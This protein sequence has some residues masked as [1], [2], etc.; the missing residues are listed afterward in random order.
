MSRRTQIL[1]LAVDLIWWTLAA[2]LVYQLFSR[3]S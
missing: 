3:L 2:V 1:L